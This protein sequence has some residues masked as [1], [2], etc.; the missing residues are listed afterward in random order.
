MTNNTEYNK[1]L[2]HLKFL[3]YKIF[4]SLH[5][6][7]EDFEEQSKNS[8]KIFEIKE[9][10]KEYIFDKKT[11]Y[12]LLQIKVVNDILESFLVN[13]KNTDNDYVKLCFLY[14]LLNTQ[15]NY[16]SKLHNYLNFE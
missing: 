5:V 11:D 7:E 6:T 14:N 10:L 9:L 1:E 16:I 4:S 15:L 2:T 13:Q 8:N 3:F 12:I